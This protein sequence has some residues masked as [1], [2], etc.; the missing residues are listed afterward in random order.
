VGR[1]VLKVVKGGGFVSH[2]SY[3]EIA[4]GPQPACAFFAKKCDFFTS[5][6]RKSCALYFLGKG[7][8]M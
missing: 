6:L 5:H 7:A 4:C 2:T 1:A 3:I 8:V